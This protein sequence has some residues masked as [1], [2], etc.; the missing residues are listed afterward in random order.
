MPMLKANVGCPGG[1]LWLPL[2]LHDCSEAA[3][4]CPSGSIWLL[5]GSIW[6]PMGSI[7]LLRDCPWG[8]YCRP[9]AAHGVH[10]AAQRLPMGSIWP[11]R[12]C[13]WLSMGLHMAAQRLYMAAH[14]AADG[15]SKA[16]FGCRGVAFCC[17]GAVYG[18]YA[19]DTQYML[20]LAGPGWA[21]KIQT[22]R[23]GEGNQGALGPLTDS[24]GMEAQDCKMHNSRLKTEECS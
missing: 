20:H 4:V 21:A 7:W 18:S 2:T 9:E 17:T 6:L 16:A 12:G 3:F 23:P 24:P 1:S 10:M 5:R 13:I 19:A 14:G 8:P 11:P 22:T 15:C